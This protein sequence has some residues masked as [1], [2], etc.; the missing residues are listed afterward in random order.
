MATL[1][2]KIKDNEKA[3][4]V[5]QLL[6]ELPFVEIDGDI[7][8]QAGKSSGKRKGKLEDLFGI[9]ENRNISL[10]NLREKAWNRN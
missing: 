3:D 8:K 4:I 7:K 6:R 2:I 1:N 10:S 5:L 9:W